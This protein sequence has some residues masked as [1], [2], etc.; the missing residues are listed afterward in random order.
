MRVPYPELTR[1]WLTRG[2]CR[3][4]WWSAAA[5]AGG[6]REGMPG[7]VP[8]GSQ[9]NEGLSPLVGSLLGALASSSTRKAALGA[10]LATHMHES[11]QRT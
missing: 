9:L 3:R 5:M 1:A 8:A 10:V 4:E 2:A 6:K 7:G 11:K